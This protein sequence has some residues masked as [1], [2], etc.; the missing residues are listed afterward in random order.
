M[1]YDLLSNWCDDANVG[2]STHISKII[3]Y[4]FS[5]MKIF[6]INVEE[7]QFYPFGRRFVW[8]FNTAA[9]PAS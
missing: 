6:L 1:R 3:N 2:G 7:G 9:G 8:F 4:Y 5:Y